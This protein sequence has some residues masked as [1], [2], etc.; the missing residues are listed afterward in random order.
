MGRITLT[1]HHNDNVA[2]LLDSRGD[3]TETQAGLTIAPNI[4]F[5][6]K[7]ATRHIRKGEAIIKYGVAIGTATADI[8][9]G[10]HVHI[11]NC[12]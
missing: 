4:A 2:T 8:E 6:H 12:Q 5:G 3:L 7:V 10:S 1:V 9:C 11:H